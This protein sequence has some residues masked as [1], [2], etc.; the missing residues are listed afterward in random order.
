MWQADEAWR[1]S[2]RAVRLADIL[3]ELPQDV[4]AA[5]LQANMDW[6]LARS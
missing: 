1:Q 3:A 2:L 6:L 5:Q 4:P